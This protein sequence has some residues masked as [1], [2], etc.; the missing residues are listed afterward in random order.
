MN[1]PGKYPLEPVN[2]GCPQAV[3]DQ[4]VS[5]CVHFGFEGW[6]IN[7]ENTLPA[8]LV[9]AML[10]FVSYLRAAIQRAVPG[11]LVIW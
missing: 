7:I 11:G 10:H 4:L 9:L 5:L 3:A 8:R 6:L 2:L 1:L